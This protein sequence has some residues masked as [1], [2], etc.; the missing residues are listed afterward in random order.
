M[1]Q[2]N[3]KRWQEMNCAKK[4]GSKRHTLKIVRSTMG[5]KIIHITQK[6]RKMKPKQKLLLIIKEKSRIN[7]AKAWNQPR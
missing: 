1:N 3:S 2:A 5:G 7:H 4:S 6:K